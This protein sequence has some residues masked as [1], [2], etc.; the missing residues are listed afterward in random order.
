MSTRALQ[1]GINKDWSLHLSRLVVAVCIV[2]GWEALGQ[3]GADAWISRPGAIAARLW[4]WSTTDLWMHLG[5]TLLEMLIGLVIGVPLG[6]L[7]GLLLGR[8]PVIN[9]LLRPI[10]VSVYNIPMIALAPLLILWFGLDL[11]PKVVLVTIVTYFI[12]F[13]A[14]FSGSESIDPDLFATLNLMGASRTE[15]F[16]KIVLP[17]STAWI[18]SA[19][20]LALPYALIDATMGEMLA[21]RQGLGFLLTNAISEVDMT[22]VFATLIILMAIGVAMVMLA[23]RIDRACSGWRAAAK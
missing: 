4:M 15:Q 17:A 23:N 8:A 12:L 6:A 5:T 18:A 22:G 11:M 13:F 14:T 3:H 20:R 9:R 7:S 1:T 2:A 21:A 19:M 10:I 16:R